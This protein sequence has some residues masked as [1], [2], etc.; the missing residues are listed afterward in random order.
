MVK[1][2]F[3]K[4]GKGPN[5]IMKG[6]I[7]DSLYM[8]VGSTLISSASVSTTSTKHDDDGVASLNNEGSRIIPTYPNESMGYMDLI[9]N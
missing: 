6:S 8:L 3:L 7:K 2:K 5:F 9:G 1:V 4:V